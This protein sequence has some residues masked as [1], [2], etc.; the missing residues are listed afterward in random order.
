MKRILCIFCVITTLFLLCSCK[1]DGSNKANEYESMKTN[2]SKDYVSEF[3]ELLGGEI[4]LGGLSSGMVL[5]E[6]HCY[7]VTPPQVA[8]ETDMKIFK[9]SDSCISL[10]LLDDQIYNLC[11]S[12]GGYGF[13]NA[14]PCDFDNDGNKDLL[15]AS[16]WG[17]GM[18]RSIISVFNSVSKESTIL[19]DTSTTDTPNADLIVA[20]STANIFTGDPEIDEKLY[21]S[22]LSVKINIEDNNLS[23][24]S[25][26][27]IGVKGHIECEDNTPQFIP[28]QE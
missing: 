9:F 22:V 28:Y 10:V 12:F 11:E 25:Y 16:S 15:I 20:Q 4:E 1:D 26:T 24:L 23:N 5:D 19:Y 13:V 2:I 3:M 18:H 27:V 8:S 7:N 17:S 14:I 21:Y 6:E